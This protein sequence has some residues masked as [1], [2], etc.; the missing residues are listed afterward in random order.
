MRRRR[1]PSPELLIGLVIL[2]GFTLFVAF[3][4]GFGG[5]GMAH[6]LAGMI[7]AVVGGAAAFIRTRR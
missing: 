5:F 7:I 4:L 6:F 3:Y 1:P 2:L